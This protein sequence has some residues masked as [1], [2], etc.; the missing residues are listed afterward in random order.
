[1]VGLTQIVDESFARHGIPVNM[2]RSP[3]VTDGM[4]Q[5]SADARAV[6]GSSNKEV[7]IGPPAPLPSGF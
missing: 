4:Q 6:R 3:I 7:Q 5:P 1:M 2:A